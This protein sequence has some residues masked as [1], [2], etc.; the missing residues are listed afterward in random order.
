MTI[1][2]TKFTPEVLLSAP[3]RSTAVPNANGTLALFTVTEYSFESHSRSYKIKVLDIKTGQSTVLS[4]DAACSEPTW[5]T[6]SEYVFV[7]S[8]SDDSGKTTLCV[9]NATDPSTGSRDIATFDGSVGNIK[10]KDVGDGTIAFACTAPTTPKG[11]LHNPANDKKQYSSARVYSSLFVRHWDAYVSKNANSVWYGAIVKDKDSGSYKLESGLVNALAGTK[12]ECPVPSFGGAEDYDISVSGIV[13]VSKDPQVNPALYTKTDLYYVP[14]RTWTEEQPPLP[15]VVKTGALRGYSN[16]PVFSHCGKKVAFRRMASDQY[17]SDKPRLLLIPD[18]DDLS[19]VQEFYKTE[20]GRGGWDQRP[21]TIAWSRDDSRL[22]VT[23]EKEG[24]TLVYEIPATPLDAK[25][26]PPRPLTK[27]STVSSFFHLGGGDDERLFINSSSLVDSSSYSVLDVKSKELS[28][29]TSSTKGGKTFGLSRSQV[30]DFWFPGAGGD[31]KC[32]A[33]VVKPSDFDAGKKYP[34]AFFIH[35]GPQGA[36]LDSWSTRWNPAIFAEQGYVVVAPNPTGSTGYGQDLTDAIATQWGGRPYNDLVNCFEHIADNLPYVDTNNAVALG[37][38]YGGYMIN[39]IQGHPLGRKFKALV[40][41]DG[42]FT[43]MADWATEELFFTMHDMGGNIWDS[44]ELYSKW[45][46]SAHVG[47]W[48]T[49]QLVIHSELDY[50]LPVSEGLAAFNALQT[51]GVPSRL[52][53]FPDENH[54]VLKPENSLVWHKEVLGWINKYTGLDTTG[55]VD[56]TEDLE[57]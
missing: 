39:W 38:S 48:A 26:E 10:V 54:W 9:A 33:L 30:D 52:L 5:L 28:L 42:I 32:H 47:E 14:L 6:D 31:Y 56:E 21:D 12:F 27:D 44:R 43:T 13:F 20:D 17:E 49:P 3:R 23:A 19:N 4:E 2:A 57:I 41:H 18:V 7:R 34:L 22:Y 15:S 35:G 37:A 24:R 46:P 51:R 1:M 8:C 16:W 45:D 29:V 55:L 11:K 53:T 25:M 40:C 50:R 36:W